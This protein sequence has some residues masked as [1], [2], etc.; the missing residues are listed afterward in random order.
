MDRRIKTEDV[1]TLSCFVTFL[2]PSSPLCT[3]TPTHS[4]DTKNSKYLTS[5]CKKK[6]R[7]LLRNTFTYIQVKERSKHDSGI[8]EKKRFVSTTQNK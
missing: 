6:F 2:I 8:L 4:Y 1:P 5:A 7:I 3:A